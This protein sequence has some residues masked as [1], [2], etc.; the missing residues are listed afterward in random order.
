MD[1]TNLY[2]VIAGFMS[3]LASLAHVGIIV[4]GAGW[5]RFFGAGETM[6]VMVEQGRIYPHIVTFIIALVLSA[7][8]YSAWSVAGVFPTY[9][10]ANIA[11]MLIT[12][13]YLIRG[14]LGFIA[15]LIDHPTTNEN[16]TAFWLWSSAICTFIG[17]MHL[18]GLFQ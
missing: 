1:M 4:G 2:L 13:V 6:A 18:V 14:V 5:Y 8:A 17:L 12:A 3:L 9:P 11:L 10:F 7:F 15:P 16:S